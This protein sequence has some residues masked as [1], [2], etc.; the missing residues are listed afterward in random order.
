MKFCQKCGNEMDDKA[1]L[2]VNC[3][4][5]TKQ[6]KQFYKKWWFWVII[7]IVVIIAASASGEG[8]ESNN[9]SSAS[10][11]TQS[12]SSEITS[13]S[14][15]SKEESSKESVS[16]TPKEPSKKEYKKSCKKVSYKS[17]ARNPAKYIGE[18]IYFK[19]KVMQV[20]ESS[21]SKTT[22][23]L[24]QVTKGEYDIWDDITY[25]TYT[26]KDGEDKILEDD[27]VKFYGE[28]KGD[29][30]YTTVL[31]ASSTVPKIEAKY[32]EIVS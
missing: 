11:P 17:I 18:N 21:W 3:G 22:T 23:Y 1:I 32:I 24:I 16:S 15:S 29:Y 31:G 9:N 8:E 12:T 10:S 26:V 30:S 5:P 27:I 25:V 19:G 13:S 14:V 28:C 6:Q 20:S 4:T 2:C 7:V